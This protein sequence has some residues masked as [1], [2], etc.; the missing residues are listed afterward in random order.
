MR[1]SVAYAKERKK[2]KVHPKTGAAIYIDDVDPGSVIDFIYLETNIYS[3]AN[4]VI[5][6]KQRIGK[7]RKSQRS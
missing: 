3:D 7:A 1:Q 4:T 2:V 6:I 5:E